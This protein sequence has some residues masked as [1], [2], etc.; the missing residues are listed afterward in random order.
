M[1]RRLVATLLLIA[2]IAVAGPAA[3][4]TGGAED[5][6]HHYA[7]AIIWPSIGHPTCSGVWTSV[8]PH[9]RPVV[10]TAAHCVPHIRASRI[11]VFFGRRW[12]A[13]APT[14]AGRSYRH[15]DYDAHTHRNDIAVILLD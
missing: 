1:V 3:A 4:V 9:R 2:P 7:A 10:V 14:M 11:R 12:H 6:G 13:G 8:G 5:D 15:P